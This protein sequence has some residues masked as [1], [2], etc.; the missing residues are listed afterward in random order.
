MRHATKKPGRNYQEAIDNMQKFLWIL[1][2]GALFGFLTQSVSLACTNLIVSKGAS[3]DGSTM[4]TY[5]ADSHELYGELYHRPAAQY[6]PGSQ[7]D[8]HEWDTGK[9]LGR[10]D[11]VQKTYEVIGNMNEHQ[12]AIGE[13][14]FGGRPEL[15]DP[16]AIMDYGSLMYVALQRAK[17]AREAI[18]I[19]GDLVSQYGYYSPGESFSI[20]DA[21]QAW[22]MDMIGKGPKNK[23]AVWVA[24]RIPDGY[25]SGHANQARIRTFPLKDKKNCLYAPDVISFARQQGYFKGQDKDFS[26]V[27]AYAP[28]DFSGLRICEARVWSMFNRAAPKKKIP[29][30]WVLGNEKATP[31]PLWIKPDRK[32]DTRAAMELM[33]DHFEST[34]MD[35]TR[36]VGAGPYGLP[37]RWRPLF[38]KVGDKKYFNERAIS[39]QQTG[40]SFVTQSRSKLPDPIGGVLWFGVDDT[41]STVYIPIYCGIR[42]VPY[43]LAEGTGNFNE[44]SWDSAFWVFNFVSNLAYSRYHD[45]IKDIQVAQRD[46]EGNFLARQKGIEKAAL[47]LYK[48][49]PE[50]ARDYLTR[51]SS[52][53]SKKT[54]DRWRSLLTE[55]LVKYL[56]GNVRDANG[57]VTHP[58]YPQ[59]W[60]QRIVK[61]H[62]KTLEFIPQSED[63]RNEAEEK[64]K[65]EEAEKKK[66]A[67]LE[68]NLPA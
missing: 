55:L 51:Y 32:L 65:K 61:D 53:Q 3:V 15:R 60:Y 34:P 19:M 17:T 49:S 57:K 18:L 30:E 50:L 68:K 45:M 4:I 52:Q 67:S 48:K 6:P 64:K 38:W 1:L 40:F 13:T 66:K 14:T 8:I 47:A 46:L 35:M 10:I 16:S 43:N 2:F 33:R 36:D 26:F 24:R 20:A 9:Y 63:I 25:I 37:Y 28:I 54:V 12:V 58:A 7:L 39:T 21:N 41:Y 42:S 44:F 59:K 62:G 5:A 22:I 23:G 27:D 29:V 31:L 56:D 11:Q